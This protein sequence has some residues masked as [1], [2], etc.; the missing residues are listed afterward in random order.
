MF[1][2]IRG[3]RSLISTVQELEQNTVLL[4]RV[5]RELGTDFKSRLEAAKELT[6]QIT[7]LA[8]A[9]GGSA[10]EAQKAAAVFLRAG[11]TQTE[12]LESV[13]ASL[14]A[15]RIAEIDVSEAATLC[16]LHYSS[17][18]YLEMIFFLFWIR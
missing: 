16:H 9:T 1:G 18:D 4:A 15:S 7:E 12:A 14:I 11:Q 2:T 6:D 3:I 8:Q 5:G 13:R 10:I 17:L